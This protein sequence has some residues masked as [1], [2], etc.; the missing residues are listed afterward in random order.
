MTSRSQYVRH[1]YKPEEPNGLLDDDDADADYD[2][3]GDDDD[4]GDY[5]D[6]RRMRTRMRRR[7]R[8]RT[9]TTTAVTTT[10]AM[11]DNAGSDVLQHEQPNQQQRLR[12]KKDYTGFGG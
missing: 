10:I 8:T 5:D 7:M 3:D 1:G 6:E 2:Y 12:R 9:K 11:G 4:D